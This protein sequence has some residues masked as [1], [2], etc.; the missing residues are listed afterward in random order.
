MLLGGDGR[1]FE[2]ENV[3]VSYDACIGDHDVETLTRRVLDRC[4]EGLHELVPVEDV[5]L[6]ELGILPDFHSEH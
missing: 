6:E 1:T 4:F 3:V 2:C 5:G